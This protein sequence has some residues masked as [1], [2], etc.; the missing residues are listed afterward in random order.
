[1]SSLTIFQICSPLHFPPPRP[2]SHV[3]HAVTVT[4]DF[5][6]SIAFIDECFHILKDMRPNAAPGPDG[7]IMAFYRAA[8][9]WIKTDIHKFISD[10]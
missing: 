8:W 1:M 4:N 6:N 9:P 5:T 10:F 3:S 7:L 2:S